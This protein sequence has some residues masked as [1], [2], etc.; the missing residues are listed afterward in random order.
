[1]LKARPSLGGRYQIVAP[2][3]LSGRVPVV[4]LAL[5]LAAE[6]EEVPVHQTCPGRTATDGKGSTVIGITAFLMRS[7]TKPATPVTTLPC[8]ISRI[9]FRL[10]RPSKATSTVTPWAGFSV[11]RMNSSALFEKYLATAFQSAS[12]SL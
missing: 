9:R 10:S 4:E 8:L 11:A 7:I 1:M 2:D 3:R 6:D 12:M 5:R